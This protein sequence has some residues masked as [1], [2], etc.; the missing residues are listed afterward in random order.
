MLI[1]LDGGIDK[2]T[3]ESAAISLKKLFDRHK[4]DMVSNT[5]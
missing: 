3:P 5:F 2:M 1:K 4:Q